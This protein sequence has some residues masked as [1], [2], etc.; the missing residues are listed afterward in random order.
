MARIK[1]VVKKK[2]KNFSGWQLQPNKRTVQGELEKVLE[3][4][5]KEN[6]RTYASGRTDTGVSSYGQVVHFDCNQNINT[7]KFLDSLN[8]LTPEDIAVTGCEILPETFDARF[9]AKKKTYQYRFYVSKYTLPLFEDTCL[10]V[11]DYVD[12]KKMD[13]ASKYFIGTHDF[14]S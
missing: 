1:L 13:E 2:K 12:I 11:N 6:I 4:L 3:F 14:G 10:R 8:G 5:L 9:S 7:K